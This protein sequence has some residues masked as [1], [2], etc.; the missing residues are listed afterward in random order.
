MAPQW[1]WKMSSRPLPVL[2]WLAAAAA[3]A[4][5]PDAAGR[6]REAAALLVREEYEALAAEFTAEMAKAAPPEMLRKAVGAQLAALGAVKQIGEPE[7]S[8]A[9]A[10]DVAFVPVEFERG[11]LRIQLSLDSEGR[12]A[13]L[14]LRPPAAP[15]WARPSYSAPEKFTERELTAGAPGWPLPATITMPRGE[16]PFPAVAL[17]HGSGPNDRDETVGAAKPFRDLAEGLASCGVAVL[18]Y[19]KR[20]RRHAARLAEAKN[21]T[22][23][24]E[25]IDDALA[26]LELLRKTPGADPKRVFLLGHSLGAWTAPLIAEEDKRLAGLILMAAPA[27]LV[28]DLYVEQVRYLLPLQTANQKLAQE[29]LAEAEREAA[30]VRQ[31]RKTGEGPETALGAPRA[32]W[33]SLR[34]LDPL[35]AAAR[36]DTPLLV[37]HGDRDYQVTND[38]FELW[39]KA[40]ARHPRAAL[41]SYPALNHLFQPGEGKSRP[42]EYQ[43]PGHVAGEVIRDLCEWIRKPR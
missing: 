2:L 31:I 15:A 29:K 40:L 18:R 12:I 9:G 23:R 42:E 7:M 43:R 38:D 14:F 6:A 21:L 37:L 22:L 19:E 30:A 41:K 32:Y 4:Q 25:V 13:G 26:A 35:A 28:E 34:G 20:T 24:E 11:S 16:G 5:S 39:R 10:L 36:L 17:V 8:K 1:W 27:R 33:N 3:C